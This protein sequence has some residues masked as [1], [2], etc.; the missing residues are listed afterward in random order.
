MATIFV[1]PSAKRYDLHKTVL[2]SVGGFFKAVLSD[3][4]HFREAMTNT[5]TLPD[6]DTVVFERFVVYVYKRDFHSDGEAEDEI[7]W[8]TLIDLYSFGE[9]R[10]IPEMQN[11]AVQLFAVKIDWDPDVIVPTNILHYLYRSTSEGSP[12]R[13]MAVDAYAWNLRVADDELSPPK[14]SY[15]IKEKGSCGILADAISTDFPS[16][17]MLEVL[18]EVAKK[19]AKLRRTRN[20]STV[21]D[22]YFVKEDY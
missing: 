7:S 18:R 8:K 15:D 12:L 13:S 10:M 14:R 6:E 5:I 16:E 17:F 21:C 1:G 4:N 11:K 2:R 20:F 3:T 9:R 22:E 19:A